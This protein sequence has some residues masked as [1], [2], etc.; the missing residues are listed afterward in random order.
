VSRTCSEALRYINHPV[1][2]DVV[3]P[4]NFTF[5]HFGNAGAVADAEASGLSWSFEDVWNELGAEDVDLIFLAKLELEDGSPGSRGDE[6]LF[7]SWAYQPSLY[8][9]A[10]I[11]G[12]AAGVA[13]DL[14]ALA[15]GSTLPPVS[16][17]R[18]LTETFA[19]Q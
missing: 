3:P 10:T 4:L 16:E 1:P 13:S 11:E 9:A 17:A 6:Y 2:H 14:E 7:M 5:P 12:F 15:S 8:R 18:V 19:A